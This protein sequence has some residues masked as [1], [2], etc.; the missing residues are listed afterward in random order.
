M[1]KNLQRGCVEGLSIEDIE[2]DTPKSSESRGTEWFPVRDE[3]HGCLAY[4]GA[5]RLWARPRCHHKHKA[6]A[7]GGMRPCLIREGGRSCDDHGYGA[8]WQHLSPSQ[9]RDGA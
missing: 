3:E 9:Q 7:R 4:G 8:T 2:L 6:T 5:V 1:S